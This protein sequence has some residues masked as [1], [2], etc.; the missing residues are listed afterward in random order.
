MSTSGKSPEM[1]LKGIEKIIRMDTAHS[2]E[3]ARPSYGG[4]GKRG[5][6]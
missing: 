3:S 6:I 1:S 2:R 4:A 5:S